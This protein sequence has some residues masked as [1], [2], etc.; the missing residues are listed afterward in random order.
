MDA[1]DGNAIGGLLREVFGT[2]M[3]TA[4]G[5]CAGCGVRAQVAEYAVY[6]QAPGAVVRCRQCGATLMVII[7]RRGMNCVDLRGL[8]ALRGRLSS[9]AAQVLSS[10]RPGHR[11]CRGRGSPAS[12]AAF[13][14]SP[15]V[16]VHEPGG[17]RASPSPRPR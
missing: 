2:E 17:C 15:A 8:A 3:T 13:H 14:C 16:P 7:T 12:G 9:A 11:R 6:R 4:V 10:L 1:L 5:T